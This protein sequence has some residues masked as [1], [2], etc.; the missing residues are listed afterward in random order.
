MSRVLVIDDEMD[1]REVLSHS[2]T[3]RGYQADT[4][5]SGE[6]G[7]EKVKAEKIDIALIDIHLPGINGIEALTQIK[8]IDPEIEV[9]MITGHGSIDSAKESMRQG[10]YD[11]VE[12]PL[13]VNRIAVLIEKALEKHQLTATV[14]LYEISKAI[15]STIEMDEL[16]KIIVDLAIKVLRADDSSI[17]LFDENGKLY[18]A[19]SHGLDEE[20]KKN[21]RLALGERIA[22]W[23]AQNKQ[24]IILIN[25]L[26]NDERFTGLEARKDIKSAVVNPLIKNNKVLGILTANRIKIE[27]NFTK[28]DLYKASI[29]ASLASL[30]LDNANLYK[31][32]QTNQLQ[33]WQSAKLAALG[34]MVSDM[35]HEVNNPLMI[36]SGSAQLCLLDTLPKDEK[37]KNLNLIIEECRKAKDIIHRLL[38][39]SHPSKGTL[40]EVDIN[41]CVESVVNILEHQFKLAGIE[42]KRNYSPSLPPVCL[43]ENQM[44]EV[45]MNLANNAK[46]AIG[47]EGK[48]IIA[49]SRE[50][51]FIKITF[52]DSGCGMA[53]GTL[54][55]LFE[56]FFTTKEEGNGLGLSVCYG[57]VKAH[58]GELQF[59]SEPGKGTI[60]AVLL[61]IHNKQDNTEGTGNA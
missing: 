6:E 48:I 24:P 59:R 2:L 43:D 29:F 49:T 1:V 52:Q 12:K 14:A 46:D 58:N 7:L 42:I 38:K 35:A 26:T 60:A 11:Y 15:F 28:I 23:V 21:T 17:M 36:I 57:I 34:R 3:R 37:E 16:L 53:E 32:L 40:K 41:R 30:A 55:H 10:A 50:N 22:G 8:N 33:L 20:Y 4:A 45:F 9:I 61:P 56:P 13:D 25:G 54:K 19:F 18:I 47:K 44:Q 39:F 51:D 27:E 31:K 5:V